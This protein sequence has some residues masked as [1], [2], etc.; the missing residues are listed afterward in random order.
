MKR[1]L[2]RWRVAVR[3]VAALLL[4]AAGVLGFVWFYQ[5]APWLRTRNPDWVRLHSAEG[6][7]HEVRKSIQR[8]GWTH[9]DFGPAG[10]YGDKEF[11]T[12]ALARTCN[13][14]LFGGCVIPI[15]I[16]SRWNTSS[17]ILPTQHS[18]VSTRSIS[19]ITAG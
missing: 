1:I 12:W 11:L 16:S 10:D 8:W 18:S 19:R 6:Y 9:D 4:L 17:L 14:T 5:V 7:W 15:S 2:K 3:I 13:T